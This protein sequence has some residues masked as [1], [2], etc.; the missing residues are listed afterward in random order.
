MNR[1]PAGKC[2]R[3]YDTLDGIEVPN[4]DIT[5]GTRDKNGDG[6]WQSFRGRLCDMCKQ[7][8]FWKNGYRIVPDTRKHPDMPR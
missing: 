3:C 6:E 8:T 4:G 5:V 1:T 2:I 7:D